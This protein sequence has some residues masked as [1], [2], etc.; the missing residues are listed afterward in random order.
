MPKASSAI[1]PPNQVFPNLNS[2]HALGKTPK[3]ELLDRL[4][5]GLPSYPY[6]LR[7]RQLNHSG[8]SGPQGYQHDAIYT[9]VFRFRLER[10]LN[11][12]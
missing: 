5:E 6:S 9:H 7:L 4:H 8:I 2:N 3:P 10:K 1:C 11:S 12:I